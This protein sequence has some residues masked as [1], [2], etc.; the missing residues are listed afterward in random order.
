M[1]RNAVLISLLTRLIFPEL[2]VCLTAIMHIIYNLR[3][4]ED[5]EYEKQA[6]AL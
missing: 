3:R 5:R 6:E 1:L 2:S 4:K